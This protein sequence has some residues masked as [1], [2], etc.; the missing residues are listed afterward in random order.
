[1]TLQ[2]LNLQTL[3]GLDNLEIVSGALTITQ[4]TF[5]GGAADFRSPGRAAGKRRPTPLPPPV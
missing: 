3:D 5:N 2:Q 1:M 4:N